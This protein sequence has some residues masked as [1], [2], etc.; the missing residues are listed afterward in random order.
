MVQNEFG[1]S[2]LIFR[3]SSKK[4]VQIIYRCVYFMPLLS[5]LNFG[6]KYWN[7]HSKGYRP[8]IEIPSSYP[9]SPH[10][11][12][13]DDIYK[14]SHLEEVTWPSPEHSG[15]FWLYQGLEA[16]HDDSLFRFGI[17]SKNGSGYK[18]NHP[19]W[20]SSLVPIID[21]AILG[22]TVWISNFPLQ[23]QILLKK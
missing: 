22:A 10:H 21:S 9:G 12:G 23:I 11:I 15:P 16:S 13:P 17:S 8:D 19:D 3:F 4:W 1:Y 5:N 2:D 6:L 18:L 20:R 7:G 14:S